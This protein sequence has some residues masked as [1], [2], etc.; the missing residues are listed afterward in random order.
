[1]WQRRIVN[2]TLDT[3][4]ASRQ[5][6][7][8]KWKEIVNEMLLFEPELV[9]FS[10]GF[11]AHK[12]D[13]LGGA[14]L[15]TEDF[16]YATNIVLEACDALSDRFGGKYVPCISVLEGGYNLGAISKSSLVH[17]QSLFSPRA[18]WQLDNVGVTYDGCVDE[19]E[20]EVQVLVDISSLAIDEKVEICNDDLNEEKKVKEVIEECDGD[21]DDA[22]VGKDATKE[23]ED[24]EGSTGS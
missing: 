22:L 20:E 6:F 3:G 24:K 13:P 17:V 4:P 21:G 9:I 1:M 23:C 12:N 8:K 11:D 14:K 10:A 16:I 7:I 15:E 18:T 2:R 19:K 5:Q